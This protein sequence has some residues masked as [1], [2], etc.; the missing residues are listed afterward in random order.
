MFVNEMMKR[1]V[2]AF[3]KN[4]VCLGPD[5]VGVCL[6]VL[7]WNSDYTGKTTRKEKNCSIVDGSPGCG[8]GLGAMDSQPLDQ[9][10]SE[11]TDLSISAQVASEGGEY[12]VKLSSGSLNSCTFDLQTDEWLF[13][14]C[15]R[16]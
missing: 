7:Y 10:N 2:R 13:A 11:N 5:C 8:G 4:C 15:K 1:L 6:K 3:R 12:R 9:S 16:R 14:D